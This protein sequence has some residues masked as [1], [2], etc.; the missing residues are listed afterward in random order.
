M[1]DGSGRDLVIL[2]P[3]SG[4]T[5]PGGVPAHNEGSSYLEQTSAEQSGIDLYRPLV[6]WA[7]VASVGRV[8]SKPYTVFVRS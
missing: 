1:Q 3:V 8:E 5:L 6:A 2:H 4:A 7:Q